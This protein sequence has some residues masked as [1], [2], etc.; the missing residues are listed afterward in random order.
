[1]KQQEKR[2]NDINKGS[3]TNDSERTSVN[4]RRK[5]V[6]AKS[7]KNRNRR[8]KKERQERERKKEK[9]NSYTK[10]ASSNCFLNLIRIIW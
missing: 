4:E 3:K 2:R 1:M 6:S 8:K 7:T 10:I 5:E 9:K